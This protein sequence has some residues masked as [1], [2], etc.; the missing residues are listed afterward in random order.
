MEYKKIKAEKEANKSG[1]GI[2]LDENKK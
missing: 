1:G 2:V